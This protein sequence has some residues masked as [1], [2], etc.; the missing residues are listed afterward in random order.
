MEQESGVNSLIRTPDQRLR[1][2]VSSTLKELAEEREAVR[3]GIHNLRLAPVMFEAGARPYPPR[4]LYR[5]YLSQSQ[6][7]LGIYW[8]SYG[9]VAPDM[10]VSGL[11]DEYEL[12]AGMPRLIYVKD[13]DAEREPALEQ[14]LERVRR[15][16]T[17][18]YSFFRDPEELRERV[19]NDLVVLLTESFARRPLEEKAPGVDHE[20]PGGRLPRPPTPLMGRQEELATISEMLLSEEASLVTLTGPGGSGKSRLALQLALDLA[21]QF[22]EGAYFVGLEA[23]TEPALML[24]TIAAV[25]GIEEAVDQDPAAP[26]RQFLRRR[27]ALLILDNLEQLLPAAADLALL[28]EPWSPARVLVTSRAPLR[29]RGERVFTVPPLAA[30]PAGRIVGAE[31]LM[32][33]PAARLFVERARDSNPG[34]ELTPATVS[35]VAELSRRLEGLPL[36]IELAAARSRLFSAPALLAR[37]DKRFDLLKGGPRDLPAR[38]QTMFDA[39]DW[40]YGLLDSGDRRFFAWLSVFAGGW[41]LEAAEAVCASAFGGVHEVLERLQVLVDGS[42]VQH[43][44]E[45]AREPRYKMLET[46]REFARARLVE[47]GE[48][49]E[50]ARNH[51][52]FFFAATEGAGEGLHGPAQQSWNRRLEADLDNLRAAMNWAIE[53]GETAR[54]LEAACEIWLF[55]EGRGHLREAVD[56]LERGLRGELSARARAEALTRLA[57]LVRPFGD[58][59]RVGALYAESLAIWREIGD[60]TGLALT[61]SNF[62]AARMY[63]GDYEAASELLEQA[64]V[65]RRRT[66]VPVHATLLN[67]GLVR[68]EQGRFAAARELYREAF[69]S[70]CRAGDEVHV[71]LIRANEAELAITQGEYEQ[72]E[73]FLGEAAVIY[74]KNGN[75]W[76]LAFLEYNRALLDWRRG[77]PQVAYERLRALV[78]VMAEAGD[79]ERAIPGL[80]LVARALADMGEPERSARLLAAADSIGATRG[81]GRAAA[82]QE[83]H[84]QELKR[85]RDALG[86]DA[87]RQA[88]EQGEKIGFEEAVA[89][90]FAADVSS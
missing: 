88:W 81:L 76:G 87:F 52:H 73:D 72:A 30:P 21:A 17:C 65:L 6:V 62:G 49:P 60:E 67:L 83:Y 63:Q 8:R 48:E 9:W 53:H 35:A 74:G 78:P 50:A 32:E 34:F 43:W 19:E 26:I 75:R 61:L 33:Y 13:P 4:Q 5:A 68:W 31:E 39:I 11:Q 16:D 15:D 14:L 58:Y 84:A 29:I 64:L 10:D 18:S 46:I 1:V 90:A 70:A 44:D 22:N 45:V 57:W 3:R 24:R 85:L 25:L 59:A 20:P 79:V 54:M 37:L 89:F 80:E 86:E 69:E 27:R 51:A 42:L 12:S 7:F 38:Q 41:T 23:L 56:W 2:F 82:H 55:W 47:A 66:G 28:L 40:S 71:A 36:A 77:E